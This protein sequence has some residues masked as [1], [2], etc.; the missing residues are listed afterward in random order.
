M[1]SRQ[2]SL[3]GNIV[4]FCRFLRTNGF[5]LSAEEEAAALQ[6]LQYVDYA[7]R[8]SLRLVLKT[9]LCRSRKQLEDFENLFNEFWI[10]LAKA[11]DAKVKTEAKPILKPGG[12]DAAF[13]SLKS[14]LNGNRNEE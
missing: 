2:T 10:E 5:T 4:L 14:W 8:N 6:A 3:S 9:V 11:I 13:K 1:I 7:E 12:R